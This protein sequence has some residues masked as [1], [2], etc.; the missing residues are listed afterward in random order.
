MAGLPRIRAST[1][2][3][4]PL[5]PPPS[6][7]IFSTGG[8]TLPPPNYNFFPFGVA[9]YDGAPTI[10][11]DSVN[12]AS[13]LAF[14]LR[15]QNWRMN[16]TL[17]ATGTG[18]PTSTIVLDDWNI[19][20]T[21]YA[22]S[23]AYPTTISEMQ[24]CSAYNSYANVSLSNIGTDTLWTIGM[25]MGIWPQAALQSGGLYLPWGS[26]SFSILF[27]T[28]PGCALD[29]GL[30]DPYGNS[31]SGVTFTVM[32]F[33]GSAG[34]SQTLWTSQGPV[35]DP[36]NLA[37]RISGNVILTGDDS[38]GFYGWNGIFDPNTGARI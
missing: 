7:A 9:Q 35:T 22:G 6:S 25:T 18:I 32:P 36:M 13:C 14:G 10:Q 26:S 28:P 34:I 11:Q 5:T 29:T 1:A 30:T 20:T 33:D 4:F 31:D 8:P 16:G 24:L 12:L 17:Y 3:G 15:V 23:L 27:Q 21:Q 38:A 37:P 19:V 2:I